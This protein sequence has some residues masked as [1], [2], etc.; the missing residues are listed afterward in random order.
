MLDHS[1]HVSSSSHGIHG[2]M[3]IDVSSWMATSMLV[4][5]R[6]MGLGTGF[7]Q[8]L[9]MKNCLQSYGLETNLTYQQGSIRIPSNYVLMLYEWSSNVFHLHTARIVVQKSGNSCKKMAIT[10]PQCGQGHKPTI[11]GW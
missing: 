6:D 10:Y 11:W 3:T 5:V 7:F 9:V 8:S 1:H 4:D 2:L